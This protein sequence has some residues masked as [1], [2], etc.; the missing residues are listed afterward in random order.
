MNYSFS[1]LNLQ[2]NFPEHV[3][4]PRLLA[5]F[6]GWL[7]TQRAGSLGYFRLESQRFDDYWIENGADLHPY[8]A[9]FM[10]TA[11]GSLVGYWHHEGRPMRFPPIVYL[12]SEGE[13][14]FVSH[15]LHDFLCR[16]AKRQTEVPDLDERDEGSDEGAALGEWLKTHLGRSPDQLLQHPDFQQWMN[17]WGK[18]KREW[19]DG[20][21]THIEIAD[22]LRKFRAPNTP[23]WQT[24]CFDVLLVGTR[25][26]M[27]H[28]SHGPQPMPAQDVAEL[29]PL[30]RTA[31]EQ[32]A[33]K[34]PERGLW[35]YAWTRVGAI[36][37]ANLC[38]QFMEEPKILDE[39]PS[40]PTS[41]YRLDLQ[42]FP[43]SRHWMPKWL[44]DRLQ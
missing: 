23:D 34:N 3:I 26:W 28:R 17:Q 2:Q 25:F 33:R 20:D 22:R 27:W 8:F 42:A 15:T 6:G 38:C 39:T 44:S 32:R 35:F 19:I 5:D 12:G 24:S 16:L 11:D 1:A 30:F 36:G 14:K 31:R 21:P 40:I 4:L 41:D 29:E 10:H 37:G 7:T 13:C 43:R 18:E 9:L